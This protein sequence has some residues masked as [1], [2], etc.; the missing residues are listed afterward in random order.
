L[1]DTPAERAGLK[2]GD[3]IVAIEGR[4]VRRGEEMQRIVWSNPG[5][6]LKFTI[7]RKSEKFTLPII[8]EPKKI[9]NA[10]GQEAEVGMI[11]I[12]FPEELIKVRY[13]IGEAIQKGGRQTIGLTVIVLKG[14]GML[15]SGRIPLRSLA[16]PLFIAQ[17]AGTAVKA[18]FTT[19]LGLIA[20]ISV[21]LFVINLL[22]IPLLDGGH[23]IFLALEGIRRKPLS[24]KAQEITQQ[25]GLT[26]ILFITIFVIYNDLVRI[27]SR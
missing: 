26:I 1:E 7:Q 17:A 20:L 8:P 13:G 25:I 27:W 24:I 6:E 15:I 19:L 9:K 21:N 14:L 10:L 2:I 22:P 18:G 4:K 11:G 23:I 3:R 16:G 12:A 5:K